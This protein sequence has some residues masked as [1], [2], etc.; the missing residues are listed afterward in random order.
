[1]N[2]IRQKQQQLTFLS[3]PFSTSCCVSVLRQ[4]A[5]LTLNFF[6]PREIYA[7]RFFS[8]LQQLHL[9]VE[10]CQLW[11]KPPA[12]E[13]HHPKTKQETH[14]VQAD[15][16]YGEE[17]PTG[18]YLTHLWLIGACNV[19]WESGRRVS[20]PHPTIDLVVIPVGFIVRGWWWV[21][22]VLTITCE[23]PSALCNFNVWY[24]VRVHKSNTFHLFAHSGLPGLLGFY[25]RGVNQNSIFTSPHV[26]QP[27][28]HH[29]LQSTKWIY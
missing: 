8:V 13:K 27:A 22:H 1:M 14:P 23:G 28:S 10:C 12:F 7:V 6:K 17:K 20:F 18:F 11:K 21:S 16:L 19:G 4:T 2:L 15:Y 24:I 26:G 25:G 5:T 29:G 3:G 9:L